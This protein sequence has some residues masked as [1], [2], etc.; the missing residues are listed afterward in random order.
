MSKQKLMDGDFEVHIP[1]IKL[2]EN[3][4]LIKKFGLMT[5]TAGGII[6]PEDQQIAREGGFVVAMGPSV[7]EDEYKIGSKVRYIKQGMEVELDGE[8]YYLVRDTDVWGEL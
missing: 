6:I 1:T 3:R 8:K 4:V 5:K 2:K 7:S